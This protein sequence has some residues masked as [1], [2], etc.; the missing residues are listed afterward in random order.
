M[1]C[2]TFIFRVIISVCNKVLVIVHLHISRACLVCP[3]T[4]LFSEKIRPKQKHH[5]SL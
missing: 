4:A 1:F 3:V 5:L 2:F